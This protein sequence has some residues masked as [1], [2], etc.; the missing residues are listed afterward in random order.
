MIYDNIEIIAV[1][2]GE[3]KKRKKRTSNKTRV[4]ITESCLILTGS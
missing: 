2:F 3:K 4:T 1:H